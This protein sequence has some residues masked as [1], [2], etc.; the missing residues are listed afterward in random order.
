MKRSM[1]EY[2]KILNYNGWSLVVEDANDHAQLFFSKLESVRNYFLSEMDRCREPDEYGDVNE[3]DEYELKEESKTNCGVTRKNSNEEI[4]NRLVLRKKILIFGATYLLQ[5][6][7]KRCIDIA[8][9]LMNVACE[10]LRTDP[11]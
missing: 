3:A 5:T 9:D 4:W 6:F 7:K 1:C 10:Q 8:V 2:V 11:E